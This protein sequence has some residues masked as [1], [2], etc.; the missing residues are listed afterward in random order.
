M[1]PKE[2]IPRKPQP[3]WRDEFSFSLSTRI[4]VEN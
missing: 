4:H 3:V 2:M 1:F